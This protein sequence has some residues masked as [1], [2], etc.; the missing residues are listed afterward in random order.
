MVVNICGHY[1][2]YTYTQST[3]SSYGSKENKKQQQSYLFL[4]ILQYTT[5]IIEATQYLTKYLGL[6]IFVYSKF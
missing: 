2:Q 5:D 1:M 4:S 6:Q 3:E